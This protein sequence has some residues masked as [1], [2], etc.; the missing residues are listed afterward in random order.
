MF[1][2][3]AE[4][5]K[6]V[7]ITL[8][9]EKFRLPIILASRS[10]SST[11]VAE[12]NIY[13]HI[14]KPFLTGSIVIQDD[15]DLY[16]KLDLDGTERIRVSYTFPD[17][18]DVITK[19]FIATNIQSATKINDYTSFLTIN[20]IE[21]V[22]F[23]DKIQK[24]SKYYDGKGEQIIEKIV[25]DKLQ[26]ANGISGLDQVFR[27]QLTA[28]YQAAFRYIVPYISP[29]SAINNI[30]YKM[31]TDTGLPYFFYATVNSDNFVLND[32]QSILSRRPFNNNGIINKPFVFSQAAT[33]SDTRVD[34]RMFTMYSFS[35][36]N[37]ENTLK[38]AQKGGLGSRFLSVNAST[39][40]LYSSHINMSNQ[41]DRLVYDNILPREYSQKFL[42]NNVFIPD[43]SGR[44]Q[45]KLVDYN[46][47][48]K[49]TVSVSK[50][51]AYEN[52]NNYS[53][54]SSQIIHRLRAVRDGFL[55]HLTKNVY[56]VNVPGLA[57]LKKSPYNT[58]GNQISV[59]VF[60]NEIPNEKVI[61]DEKKSGNYIILAKRHVFDVTADTH[62]VS[63]EIARISNQERLND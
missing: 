44:S 51:Y 2:Q 31:T 6:I 15:Q 11:I 52:V 37:L 23:F 5:V 16:R 9:S 56:L 24:F 4:Q 12:V 63:M 7:S 57:F 28:S 36:K 32:M 59:N 8:E 47:F 58:I 34:N 20:L 27:L 1:I 62:N 55:H 19:T 54:E 13:E 25:N 43:P 26:K 46:S 38:L 45:E 18:D 42:F 21:D 50:M 41:F 48:I 35:G 3:S 33:H 60:A 53:E 61:I 22:G 10:P 40:D 49:S 17:E 14:T 29:L 30:L 39:G